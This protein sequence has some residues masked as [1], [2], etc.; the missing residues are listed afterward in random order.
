VW[1]LRIL[2]LIL[3]CLSVLL[4]VAV[5]LSVGY[6]L[7]SWAERGFDNFFDGWAWHEPLNDWNR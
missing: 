2:E 5:V 3:R 6:L 1:P 7:N 4:L